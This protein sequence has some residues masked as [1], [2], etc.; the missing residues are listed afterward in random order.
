MA[1]SSGGRGGGARR[2]R[3]SRTAGAVAVAGLI[4]AAC[5]SG[6]EAPSASP[7]VTLAPPS[8]AAPVSCPLGTALVAAD[9]ATGEYTRVV[10]SIENSSLDPWFPLTWAAND[11]VAVPTRDGAVALTTIS[12]FGGD[13]GTPVSLR[14]QVTSQFPDWETAPVQVAA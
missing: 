10:A 14:E 4:G 11:L 1:N 13:T 3:G 12:G 6:G 9:L 5:G 2:S 7:M 8:G